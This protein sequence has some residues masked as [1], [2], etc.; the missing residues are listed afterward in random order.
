MSPIACPSQERLFAFAVGELPE[1]D[2][3]EVA[4]HLDRC[5]RC[6]EQAGQFDRATDPILVGLKLIGNSGL[7]TLNAAQQT[8]GWV[9]TET[10]RS[11][12]RPGASSGSS[13]RS[14]GAAWGSSTRRTRGRSTATWP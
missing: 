10:S 7:R 6:D 2:L 4:E 5:I 14:A 1:T 11:W 13:A 9:A 8:D 3:S 12:P